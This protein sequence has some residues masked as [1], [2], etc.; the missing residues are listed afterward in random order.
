MRWNA[1]RA[2]LHVALLE[3][4][5]AERAQGGQVVGVKLEYP[6]PVPYRVGLPPRLQCARCLALERFDLGVAGRKVPH[7]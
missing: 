7:V 3:R 6:I 1:A 4:A 2:S 5:L